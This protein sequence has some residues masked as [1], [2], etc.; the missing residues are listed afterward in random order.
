VVVHYPKKSA[1]G[2]F[3]PQPNRR[4]VTP[5]VTVHCH[6]TNPSGLAHIADRILGATC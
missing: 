2:F 1:R 6:A 3:R 4:Q 5:L